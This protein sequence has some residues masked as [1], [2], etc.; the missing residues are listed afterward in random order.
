MVHFSDDM[1]IKEVVDDRSEMS[2]DIRSNLEFANF[3]DLEND[4]SLDFAWN[5]FENEI[6]GTVPLISMLEGLKH[7]FRWSD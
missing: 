2:L 7:I 1:D 6:H 5:Y 4:K 3:L